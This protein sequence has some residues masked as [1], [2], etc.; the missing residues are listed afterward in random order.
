MEKKNKRALIALGVIGSLLAFIALIV[1]LAASEIVTLE[2]AKLMLAGLLGMYVGFG[3]LILV[4]V[5]IRDL[6]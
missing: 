6:E 1:F 2:M 3:F 4:Y 5:L